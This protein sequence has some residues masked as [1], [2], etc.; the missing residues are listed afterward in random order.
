MD[1]SNLNFSQF[2]YI[3][4]GGSGWF[5]AVTIKVL[6]N[7]ILRREGQLTPRYLFTSGGVPSVHASFVSSVVLV[8]GLIE[9]FDSAVFGVGLIL[10]GVV[11]YDA[12]GVRRATGENTQAIQNILW[13]GRYPY[14][15][16]RLSLHLARGHTFIQIFIGLL[17]GVLCG[18][19][20][21]MLFY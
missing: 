9:G 2:I 8:V 17:V 6:L 19:G 5:A 12:M 1:F 15:N 16:K 18:A 10:L 13:Q 3:V 7:I 20:N 11:I 4:A 14:D 21:Y